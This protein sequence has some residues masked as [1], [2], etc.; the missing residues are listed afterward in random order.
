MLMG[1]VD[2][3][4][5]SEIRMTNTSRSMASAS[6]EMTNAMLDGY[7][8]TGANDSLRRLQGSWTT[9]ILTLLWRTVRYYFRAIVKGPWG[10][11]IGV[12]AAPIIGFLIVAGASNGRRVDD[13]AVLIGS[14][15]FL[16]GGLLLGPLGGFI[17][18]TVR[19]NTTA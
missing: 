13:N 15:I 1:T 4:T 8:S 7:N 9:M 17:Q 14:L 3:S 10:D 16:F 2:S 6:A 19:S 11:R 18:R 12:I 5:A